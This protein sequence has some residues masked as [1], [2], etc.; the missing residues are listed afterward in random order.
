MHFTYANY[1]SDANGNRRTEIKS[2]AYLDYR[3]DGNGTLLVHKLQGL[4]TLYTPLSEKIELR[5]VYNQ[6]YFRDAR[7]C[8]YYTTFKNGY[9]Y[10]EEQYALGQNRPQKL[11]DIYYENN[12]LIK[13]KIYYPACYDLNRFSALFNYEQKSSVQEINEYEYFK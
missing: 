8:I 5:D 12:N 9:L 10:S 2:I 7:G 1:A 4:D 13:E 6:A 3:I 11:V